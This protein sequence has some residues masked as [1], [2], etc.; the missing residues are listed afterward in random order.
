MIKQYTFTREEFLAICQCVVGFDVYLSEVLDGPGCVSNTDDLACQ[1]A[2][3]ALTREADL[4]P[5]EEF[6]YQNKK[7]KVNEPDPVGGPG[8][9]LSC[10]WYGE[11]ECAAHVA[12]SNYGV[13]E[14]TP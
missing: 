14:V 1:N 9:C 7:Y 4:K 12:C 13:T 8:P 11:D 5:G 10:S 3:F 6:T 2:L